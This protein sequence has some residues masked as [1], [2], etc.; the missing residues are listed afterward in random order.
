MLLSLL[1]LTPILAVAILLVWMRLP[2]RQAMPL[3]YLATLLFGLD[4][5]TQSV[6]VIVYA[7]PV[8][9]FTIIL[10]TEFRTSP[11]FVT[12]AVVTSTLASTLTLTLVIPM[13]KSF[14]GE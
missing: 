12:N 1:A 11:K 13:V 10:S 5:L 6:V 14:I 8:A 4:A 7:M 2:A 9:V 3:A